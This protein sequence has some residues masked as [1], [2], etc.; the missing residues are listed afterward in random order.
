MFISTFRS[1]TC[2]ACHCGQVDTLTLVSW[3]STNVI[4]PK[5]TCA[6]W[7]LPEVLIN[8][9]HLGRLV[10][11]PVGVPVGGAGMALE[12]WSNQVHL[13]AR[14]IVGSEKMCVRVRVEKLL[15]LQAPILHLVN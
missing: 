15:I 10:P 1:L 11:V 5:L 13:T 8:T 7:P 14:L 6:C 2:S 9:T 3:R 4:L 12:W